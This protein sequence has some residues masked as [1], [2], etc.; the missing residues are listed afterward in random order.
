MGSRT[1]IEYFQKVEVDFHTKSAFLEAR[2]Q[3]VK[4]CF[5]KNC[6]FHPNLIM[7]I[8]SEWKCGIS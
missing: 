2:V 8:S 1:G 6:R 3:S 7:V 5:P 4:T